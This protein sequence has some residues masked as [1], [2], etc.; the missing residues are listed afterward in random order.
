MKNWLIIGN[1]QGRGLTRCLQ[2]F[3]PDAA[4][5]TVPV[6]ELK[7]RYANGAEC[8]A[9]V[10][11]FDAVFV[12]RFG[13]EVWPETDSEQ[14]AKAAVS[15]IRYPALSFAA[16]HPDLVY[17]V[18]PNGH[19]GWNMIHTPMGDY[20]SAL[21][22]FAFLKGYS[23]ARA[24]QLFCPDVFR[25]VGYLDLWSTAVDE[26]LQL[27]EADQYKLSNLL[28]SW[29][30]RGCFMHSSVHPRIGPLIDLARVM[31]TL[32]GITVT[33]EDPA[34]FL[35]DDLLD[36]AVWPIY[37]AVAERYGLPSGGYT[38]KRNSYG[39]DARWPEFMGL[40]QFIEGSY[41]CYEEIGRD[42]LKC[43]RVEQWLH[44]GVL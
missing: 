11:S 27:P 23:P 29:S 35:R 33:S 5:T 18:S 14:I 44:D 17:V 42:H 1:C 41:Q 19:S 22:L 20:N 15:V 24:E 31:A 3:A 34:G 26:L 37:P 2:F 39:D 13:P 21:I 43:A 16:Y 7:Q 36:S 12:H 10:R 9:H 8:L 30:R 28:L 40:R 25:R 32:A 38:F 4:L 6:W